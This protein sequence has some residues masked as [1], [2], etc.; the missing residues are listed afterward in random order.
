M[1]VQFVVP[2]A[3]RCT[4]VASGGAWTAANAASSKDTETG[5]FQPLPIKEAEFA[6]INVRSKGA[7]ATWANGRY[8]GSSASP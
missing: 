1:M 5:N 2:S 3:M 6:A 7:S 4:L 8:W